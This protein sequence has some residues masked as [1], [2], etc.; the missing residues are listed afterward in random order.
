MQR[1]F[2]L[3]F[4]K[5][6]TNPSALLN[7]SWD[8]QS[9]YHL[10]HYFTHYQKYSTNHPEIEIGTYHQTDILNNLDLNGMELGSKNTL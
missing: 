8:P 6:F 1:Y 5:P 3:H 9:G 10:C 4:I 2:H 7:P